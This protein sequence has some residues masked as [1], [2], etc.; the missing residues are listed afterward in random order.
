[1]GIYRL[2]RRLRQ[3]VYIDRLS[4]LLLKFPT[5][6][7]ALPAMSSSYNMKSP[8][9]I[10]DLHK[11]D[12][13]AD[14]PTEKSEETVIV[15]DWDENEAKNPK[16]WSKS[17]KCW[18]AL[19]LWM[20]GFVGS[21]G[22]SIV[23][24]AQNPISVA[25]GVSQDVAVL[26]VSFYV[27]GFACGP[28][29][30]APVGEAK[31]RRLSLLP[32][33]FCLGLFSIGT[34]TSKSAASIFVTRF[35]GGVF[36]SSPVSSVSAMLGDLWNPKARGKAQGIFNVANVGSAMLGPGNGLPRFI[37]TCSNWA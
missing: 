30:W 32:A 16:N 18:V 3:D 1:M 12:G 19:Q 25:T 26:S 6:C 23:S 5:H 35:F 10:P 28:L 11:G 14:L 2:N 33:T 15:V 29:L 31:G 24:P 17:Y 4:A 37:Q 34:A 9:A 20:L 7:K 13:R 8:S 21:L 36:G 22:S 27:L